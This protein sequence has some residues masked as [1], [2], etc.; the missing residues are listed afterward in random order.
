[1]LLIDDRT[2]PPSE[3]SGERPVWEP[4]WPPQGLNR[5]LIAPSCFF[6]NVS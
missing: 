1:M 6:W 4:N 3:P 5:I 2:P